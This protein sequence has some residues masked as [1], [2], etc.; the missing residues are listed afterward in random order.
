MTHPHPP[1][2]PRSTCTHNTP[3]PQATWRREPWGWL[4]NVCHPP[5]VP[6]APRG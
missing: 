4:C 5:I 1:T 6:Q 3:C 2:T